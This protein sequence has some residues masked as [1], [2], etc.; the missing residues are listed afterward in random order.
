MEVQHVEQGEE[1]HLIMVVLPVQLP[2]EE[3]Y[4]KLQLLQILVEEEQ[5]EHILQAIVVLEDLAHQE[6]QV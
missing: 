3:Q 2:A 1:G 6:V 4:I 5:Q